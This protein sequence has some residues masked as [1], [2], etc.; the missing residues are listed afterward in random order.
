MLLVPSNPSGFSIH[1]T[2]I[3]PPAEH[4]QGGD[5]SAS[6]P[7]GDDLPSNGFAQDDKAERLRSA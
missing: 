1:L 3:L 2:S 5:M 4:G 6:L 7:S